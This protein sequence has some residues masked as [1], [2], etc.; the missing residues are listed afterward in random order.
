M[1]YMERGGI[2]FWHS[3]MGNGTQW[4]GQDT[5]LTWRKHQAEASDDRFQ[6]QNTQDKK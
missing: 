6:L 4:I 1:K 3:T 5:D 2:K